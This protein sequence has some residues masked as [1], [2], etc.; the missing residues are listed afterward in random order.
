KLPPSLFLDVTPGAATPPY[1]FVIHAWG[2]YYLPYIEQD[3][4]YKQ[5]DLKTPFVSPQNVA[6][7][8]NKVSTFICPSAAHSVDVYSDKDTTFG[9]TW[10]AAVSDYAPNSSINR[11]TFFGY[12]STVSQAQTQSAMRGIYRGPAATLALFGL[13]PQEANTMVGITDGTSNTILLCE[14]AGRPDRWVAGRLV[15]RYVPG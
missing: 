6:V 5:Y 13:G 1:P 3:N 12:P 4:L 11:P 15:K 8:S 7:I 2:P 9:F 10:N 14:D